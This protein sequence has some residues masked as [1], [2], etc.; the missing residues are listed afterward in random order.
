[1]LIRFSIS[2]FLSFKEKNTLEM[3]AGQVETFKDHLYTDEK[4][5][6]SFLKAGVIYGAN[7]SG[8]SNFVKAIDFAQNVIKSGL[9]NNTTTNKYFRLDADSINKPSLFQF[10]IKI[11]NKYFDYGFALDLKNKKI[12]EEWLYKK[13]KTKEK[14]IFHR[15]SL[16]IKSDVK[17]KNDNDE[18]RFKIYSEDIDNESLFLKNLIFKSWKTNDF[19][20]ANDVYEWFLKKLKIIYPN[21]SE[22]QFSFIEDYKN[23]EKYLNAYDTGI[24]EVELEEKN[25]DEFLKKI[26]QELSQ[27]L[28]ND[29]LEFTKKFENIKK[30]KEKNINNKNVEIL[31]FGMMININNIPSVIEISTSGKKT[32]KM[33]SFK[34]LKNKNEIFEITDESDGTRRLIELI[35]LFHSFKGTLIIDELDRSFHPALTRKIFEHFYNVSKGKETQLIATTHDTNLLTLNFLRRDEIWFVDREQDKSSRI[36]SLDEFK[37]RKDKKIDKAYFL[38]RYGGV[39]V[40]G[41]FNSLGS[42]E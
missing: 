8:K 3:I 40:F 13:M 16:E 9:K 24:E 42:E 21:D 18:R 38:G 2:N 19:L 31:E 1:M 35:P 12:I 20:V 32:V 23:F 26:P 10:E 39:P 7:A 17:F 22:G 28:E 6:V 15:E 33:L 25:Y 37:D 14:C 30:Q 4:S 36:Y 41:D 27:R 11:D 29:I 34:H 5:K